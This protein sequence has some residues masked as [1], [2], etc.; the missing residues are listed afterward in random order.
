MT[1][2]KSRET[3]DGKDEGGWWK[4]ETK[5][6]SFLCAQNKSSS[7]EHVQRETAL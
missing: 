6:K 1:Q 4:R 3:I 2:K 5:L 7:C